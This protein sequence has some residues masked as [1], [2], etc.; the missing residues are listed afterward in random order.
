MNFR[1]LGA[2]VDL[3][4]KLV[5]HVQLNIRIRADINCE[6]IFARLTWGLEFNVY[7]FF[8]D[9]SYEFFNIL[10]LNF[11]MIRIWHKG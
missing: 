4:G 3:H 11:R 6:I 5:S 7:L 1:Y 9:F 2:I 8:V 10:E